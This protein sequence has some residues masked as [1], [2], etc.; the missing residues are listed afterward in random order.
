MSKPRMKKITL[1]HFVSLHFFPLFKSTGK[2]LTNQGFHFRVGQ[3]CRGPR[4]LHVSN[5]R[6]H[7]GWDEVTE[8]FLTKNWCRNVTRTDKNRQ[9]LW[10]VV[11]KID[12]CIILYPLYLYFCMKEYLRFIPLIPWDPMVSQDELT[13]TSQESRLG[14]EVRGARLGKTIWHF[15]LQ[16]YFGKTRHCLE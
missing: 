6:L 14:K 5:E 1:L 11:S 2:D 7:R 8:V 13:K 15:W 16:D 3:G 10:F 9:I 12:I 4:W